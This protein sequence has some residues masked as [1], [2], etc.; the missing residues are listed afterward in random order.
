VDVE[1]DA[2]IEEKKKARA[3]RVKTNQQAGCGVCPSTP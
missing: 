1:K 3:M 2:F